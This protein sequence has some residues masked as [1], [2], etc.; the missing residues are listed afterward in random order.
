MINR[1]RSLF[2]EYR[3][4]LK[5][6]E[7]E[8]TLDL[9]FFRPLAFI[10]VKLIQNSSISPNQV[11]L[12]SLFMGLIVGAC[13]WQGTP[14][15]FIVGAIFL[16]LTNVFDCADGMLARVRGT[17]SVIGYILDG[18]VD[19]VTHISAF[20][21][22]LHGLHVMGAHVSLVWGVGVP[23]GLSF[24]WWCAMVDRGRTEWSEKVYDKRHDPAKE[25][26]DLKVHSDRWHEEGSHL[27]ERMLIACYGLYIRLWYSGPVTCCCKD[28]TLDLDLW[29][30]RHRPLLR[31]SL[32]LGP[33]THIFLIIVAG[34]VNRFEWYLWFAL[35]AGTSWGLLVTSLRIQTDRR[36]KADLAK[37]P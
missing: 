28:H 20:V 5:A 17:S 14:T 6:T 34:L 35:V 9:I 23:A 10:L 29:Q 1:L 7:M 25:L 11:T 37:G 22:M 16:L 30:R 18:L 36:L 27:G 3:G 19:Y 32:V 24:A 15:F 21:G 12:I 33:T 13:F 26:A 31:M 2:H 8:E 4:M